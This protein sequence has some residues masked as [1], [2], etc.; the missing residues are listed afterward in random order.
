MDLGLKGR[1]AIICASSRGLGRG[2]ARALALEGV[3]VVINGRDEAALEKTAVEIA[4][5]SGVQVTPVVA[6]ISTAAGRAALL[7]ACP[8][9]DILVN[10][11]G[12]PPKKDFRELDRA[13]MEEGVNMNM[14]TPIELIQA[15]IDPMIARKFGRIVNIT[16]VSVKMPVMGLDLSSGARGGLT[17]FLAGVAR[18]VARHNVTINHLLPGFFDTDRIAS[19]YGVIAEAEGKTVEQVAAEK[20]A[21]IPGRRLG[22]PDE[23]GRMCAYICSS[24]AGYLVGQSILL[25]GGLYNSVL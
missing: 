7:A 15:V 21:G 17:A 25:D 12:G 8:E 16:S 24:Q 11:N 18:E 13:A 19:L 4:T 10:N 3:D 20:A 14:I 6:D 2:C 9:P 5:E 22:S 1:T 23:F